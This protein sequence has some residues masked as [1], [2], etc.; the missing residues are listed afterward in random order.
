MYH[1]WPCNK[2]TLKRTED[3]RGRIQLAWWWH[4][5]LEMRQQEGWGGGGK[6]EVKDKK[7]NMN[8]NTWACE[9]AKQQSLKYCFFIQCKNIMMFFNKRS[10]PRHLS[11]FETTYQLLA[12]EMTVSSTNNKQR[13]QIGPYSAKTI[14][15]RSFTPQ[16][17]CAKVARQSY[18]VERI[19]IDDLK[20][21]I[22]FVNVR[23][24][25]KTSCKQ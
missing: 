21:Y 24:M 14:T 8:L 5:G 15:N 22:H 23:V 6:L 20:W 7:K 25:D 4:I 1:C 16:H 2:V 3:N 13:G 18:T 12:H 11:R 19:T 9:I 17:T 10:N